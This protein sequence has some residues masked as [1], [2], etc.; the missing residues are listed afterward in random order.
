ID[1][2]T[3]RYDANGNPVLVI[4]AEG[5]ATSSVYDERD[6]LLR[7]TQGATAPPPGALL[8]PGDP[9]SYDVR[10]G[11]SATTTYHYDDNGNLNEVVDASD[12][13]GSPAN[14]SD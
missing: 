4:E 5:N 12:T 10:G 7:R 9:T 8:A 14:N 13:D 11:L 6:L 1:P 2:A 3:T